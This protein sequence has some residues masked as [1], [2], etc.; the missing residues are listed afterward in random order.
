MSNI[1][2]SG[3]KRAELM[4][5][6]A[7]VKIRLK[8]FRPYR[9]KERVIQCGKKGCWCY[10]GEDGHGPYLFVTYR[11]AGKTKSVSIGPK[12]AEWELF[13][14]VPDLPSILDYLTISDHEYMDMPRSETEGWLHLTL[15]PDQF[16]GR[17]GLSKQEDTFNRPE[18]FWGS[19]EAYDRYRFDHDQALE[20]QQV[21]YNEWS[22]WGV[23]TLKGI[24]I[25][26]AL[27]AQGYYLKV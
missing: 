24:A 22:G 12:L 18:K 19:E 26:E 14:A 15:T 11:Q 8:S 27:E 4:E 23:S 13:D 1:D 21:P 3:I 25:L 2:L 20:L 9:I 5:L 7:E 16:M 10:D 17:H 6:Q